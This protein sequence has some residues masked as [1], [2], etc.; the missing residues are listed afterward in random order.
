[1][2][3]RSWSARM[4]YAARW[5][6]IRNKWKLDFSFLFLLLLL[7]LLF[8][9]G[10]HM[11]QCWWIVLGSQLKRSFSIFIIRFVREFNRIASASSSISMPFIAIKWF[12][13]YN[14]PLNVRCPWFAFLFFLWPDDPTSS[15]NRQIQC[16]DWIELMSQIYL[17]MDGEC[18]VAVHVLRQ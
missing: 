15:T 5:K 4:P 11:S 12:F 14:F 18:P 16:F 1:M 8:M 3:G 6:S 10:R 9:I 2:D 17:L 7:L 13:G